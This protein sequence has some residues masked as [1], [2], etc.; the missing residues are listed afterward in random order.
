MPPPSTPDAVAIA[1]ISCPAWPHSLSLSPHQHRYQQQPEPPLLCGSCSCAAAAAVENQILHA[2]SV[3]WI[4]TDSRRT[5]GERDRAKNSLASSL[6]ILKDDDR[7]ERREGRDTLGSLSFS[8]AP[9]MSEQKAGQATGD[10]RLEF[11]SLTEEEGDR[12]RC[13]QSVSANNGVKQ[14]QPCC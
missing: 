10:C 2:P 8:C 11:A 5:Q 6:L 13:R 14:H 9:A 12:Y 4:G 1:W 3:P 7:K